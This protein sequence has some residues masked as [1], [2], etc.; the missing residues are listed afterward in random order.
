MKNTGKTFIKYL[1]DN[2]L[3]NFIAFII[4]IMA[5]RLVSHFFVTRSVKNL[6]GL[7]AKRMVID[8]K[9]YTNLELLISVMIGFIV[10]EIISKWLSRKIEE[11]YPVCKTV[12][13]SW[14]TKNKHPLILSEKVD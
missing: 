4:G 1:Y 6:W 5:T 10:F 11:L 14:F 8:K 9:T 3:S 2:F 7:T 12:V 13:L